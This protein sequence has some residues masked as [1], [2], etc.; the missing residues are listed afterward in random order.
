MPVAEA[1]GTTRQLRALSSLDLG[2]VPRAHTERCATSSL[3][4]RTPSSPI[5]PIASSGWTARPACRPGSRRA[6]PPT[7]LN[8]IATPSSQSHVHT[9]VFDQNDE[10]V[11][12]QH[13]ADDRAVLDHGDMTY[14]FVTHARRDVYPR[15]VRIGDHHVLGHHI[16]DPDLAGLGAL[17]K[18]AHDI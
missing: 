2:E 8:R 14:T 11:T 17:R 18:R 3:T 7:S 15:L 1:A 5:A 9:R 16:G 6:A 13:D 4:I 12:R 10:Y